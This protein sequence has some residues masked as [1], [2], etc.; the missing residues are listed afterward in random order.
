MHDYKVTLQPFKEALNVLKAI[1]M[2][3]DIEALSLVLISV[4]AGWGN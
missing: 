3:H 4:T 2:S 1:L